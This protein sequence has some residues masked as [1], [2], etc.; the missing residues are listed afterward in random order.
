MLNTNSFQS[1]AECIY[2]ISPDDPEQCDMKT[3]LVYS[4]SYNPFFNLSLEEH[5][6]QNIKEDEVIFYLWQNAHTIVIGRNQNPYR[7][8]NLREFEAD[9]GKLARRMSGGGAV[10]HDLGNLNFT[11]ILPKREFN[12]IKQFEVIIKALK[13]I[14]ITAYISGRNDLLVN[15][16]KFSGNAFYHTDKTS[17]HHGTILIDVC[18]EKIQKYLNVSK[19]KLKSKGVKSVRSRVINLKELKPNL[20]IEKMKDLLVYGFSVAYNVPDSF[21]LFNES[22][23]EAFFSILQKYKS[24]EWRYGNTPEFSHEFGKRFTWGEIQ[25]QVMVT[26]GFIERCVI[27]SDSLEPDLIEVLSKGLI[28]CDFH[29]WSLSERVDELMRKY[30]ENQIYMTLKTYFLETDI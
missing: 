15:E 5:L 18:P 23:C 16:K 7:E 6:F 13:R 22:H 19:E 2:G 11:F 30:G 14:G 4:D 20:T 26:K 3:K 24:H 9:R 28:G 17:L 12:L 1:V 29:H 10:Y 25:F 27:F 8:C 21:S